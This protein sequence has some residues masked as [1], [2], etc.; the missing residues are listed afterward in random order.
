MDFRMSMGVEPM[1]M[2]TDRGIVITLS[3]SAA[4]RARR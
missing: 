3:Y 2:R 4:A 1:K